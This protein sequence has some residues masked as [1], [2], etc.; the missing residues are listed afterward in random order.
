MRSQSVLN[1]QVSPESI[2]ITSTLRTGSRS[3]ARCPISVPTTRRVSPLIS[4]LAMMLPVV[5]P[6]V[7]SACRGALMTD[8]AR[9]TAEASM[10]EVGAPFVSTNLAPTSS[11]RTAFQ[12]DRAVEWISTSERRD[13]ASL[14]RWCAGVG[15]VAA[16]S[17]LDSI[18]DSGALAADS[19]VVLT[20]NTHVGG[21]DIAGMVRDL[22]AGR[23]TNGA[24]VPHFVLLLQ[25]AYR[26]SADVPF[27]LDVSQPRPQHVAPER[28]RRV[29]IV[30]TAR[31]LGLAL[32]YVP[33]MANGRPR[34]GLPEDR[35]NA[36][37]STLP[38][39][40][41][42]AIELPF[43]AQRR[44]AAAAT[45]SGTTVD[46][47]P[48]TLRLVNVHLDNKSRGSRLLQSFGG[49]RTRQ[50]R[51][52]VQALGNDSATV[53]GGDMNTWSLG[54][55]EGAVGVLQKHFPLPAKHPTEPTF[56]SGGLRLDRLMY[57]LPAKQSAET[58]RL[59]DRHGSDHHPL[60]GT[61]RFTDLAGN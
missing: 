53:V 28:T 2:V 7:L 1:E 48:W 55:M 52:L 23:L 61:I 24:P 19:L 17:F 42:A 3:E 49:A 33:S 10:P 59:V 25:E 12:T 60:I 27:G 30:E 29:D 41:F 6:V 11:C 5:L 50:A 18:S 20:W 9:T 54:F 45:V 58:R 22:R 51:A 57:R 43:E 21:G 46:G 26:A 13:R 47:T 4:L 36:I 15:P 32:F 37:L 35:G 38:L 44:V 39:R 56:A 16:V 14:D 8:Q 31:A 40:D 34:A